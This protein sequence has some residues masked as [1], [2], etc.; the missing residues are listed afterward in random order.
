MIQMLE[1]TDKD[2]KASIINVPKDLKE[3]MVI[4]NRWE[5]IKKKT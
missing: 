4:M 3:N 1:L 5:S 2:L